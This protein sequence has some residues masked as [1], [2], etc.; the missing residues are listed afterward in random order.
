MTRLFDDMKRGLDEVA[1]FFR[2][3]RDG[4]RVKFPEEEGRERRLNAVERVE[5]SLT[6][7]EGREITEESKRQLAEDVN[8]PGSLRLS[9]EANSSRD[10]LP[11]F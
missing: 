4:Y 9:A 8:R 2:G 5:A 3:E 11:G 7:G 6:C 1:A 10:K